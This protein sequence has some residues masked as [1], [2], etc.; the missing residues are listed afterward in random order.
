MLKG[1]AETDRFTSEI[2][3]YFNVEHCFL[4][5]SGKAALAIILKALKAMHPG[6]DEVL[7]P[8]FTCYSVPSAIVRAGLKVRLGDVNPET[9][10]FDF[11]QLKTHVQSESRL[12]AVVCP[13]LFAMP[14]DLNAAGSV[15]RDTKVV[16]VEDAAQ[17]MGTVS[18]NAFLGTLGDV[19]FFSLGRGKAFS[20]VEGGVIVA[21]SSEIAL[22]IQD[23]MEEVG[24]AAMTY[25]FKI[26][27]YAM[28]LAVLMRPCLF[29][30]P[31]SI[32]ALKL[33]QTIY[34]PGFPIHRLS[35]FQ[36]GLAR[37]WQARIAGMQQI[38]K[39]NGSFW[40]KE[41]KR[42]AWL[43]P[44][45]A[46]PAPGPETVPLIRFPVLVRDFALRRKLLAKSEKRGLGIMPVYPDSI[47]RVPGLDIVNKNQSFPGAEQCAGRLVTF[48]VH[49]LVTAKDRRKILLCLEEMENS[50]SGS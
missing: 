26:L 46:K 38:R 10:D 23:I 34:D 19:G 37:N 18:G 42:F 21:R 39:Q 43:Q 3:A 20:T 12:L 9:L 27:A 30:I 41:L 32:P 45:P 13:H 49:G 5:S 29:W 33:G 31:K 1:Q 8:A 6:C 14:A 47:D 25:P 2:E 48:P 7:V 28:A 11:E 17:A 35:P 15:L 16:I 50:E 40:E 22:K 24:F 4:L 36:A 44:I